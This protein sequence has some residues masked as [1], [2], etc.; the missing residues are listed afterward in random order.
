VVLV[1]VLIVLPGQSASTVSGL[2]LTLLILL[3]LSVGFPVAGYVVE[4]RDRIAEQERQ[5]QEIESQQERA[6]QDQVHRLLV[7]GS[8]GRLPQLSELTDDDLGVTPTRYSID[9]K[10]PYV[11]RVNADQEIRGLLAVP[12]PPYPFVIVWGPT[13]AGKSRTLAE[14]LRATFPG[15]A[16][17]LLPRSGQ[18]LAELVRLDVSSLIS[19]SPAVVVLDDLDPAGLEALTIDAL[20]HVRGRAVIAATMTAQRRAD[21]LTTG[22]EVG[23][24]ARAALAATSGEY[25]LTSEPPVGSERSEAER[26]YPGERFDGSIAETLVGARELIARYKASY[27]SHPAGCAVM[28]AAIDARRAGLHRPITETELWRLFPP[29]LH[30]VRIGLTPT[31]EQFAAGIQWAARPVASQVALLRPA[32]RG[33]GPQAWI[34]FDHAVAADE[35]YGGDL[36][37]LPANTWSELIDMLP[38]RDTFP[39]GMAALAN[40]Q[41]T[42]AVMAFRKATESD[43]PDEASMAAYNLGVLLAE[44]GDLDGA[45]A[46][47]QQAVD[48]GDDD[49]GPVAAVNLGVVLGEL[50]DVS[51][52]QAIFRQVI[53]S[54]H[55]EQ[56][57]KAAYNLGIQLDQQ[58]DTNGARAAYQQAAE[59]GDTEA[60]LMAALNLGILLGEQGDTDDACAIFQRV[61]KSHN[62]DQAPKAAY[63]LGVVLNKKGDLNGARA[64]YQQAIDSGDPDQAPKAA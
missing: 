60:S 59:F 19:R 21:V 18:A 61:I 5:R 8:Y 32:N 4:R 50:G 29:Y 57:P 47:Y 16:E 54:G 23:N 26:L 13:K 51:A 6:H 3:V 24:I 7:R 43:Q 40:H 27:D 15:D 63:S 25:E 42:I 20:E 9:G 39:V 2:I 28:R 44:L 33:R 62:A 38:P 17:V 56:A 55:P 37:P 31:R 41:N 34:V 49:A 14:A 10:A 35:G 11:A 30:T 12:G 64:A 22:S 52:A 1:T 48:S 46:A 45:R 36:R 53:D 58:G